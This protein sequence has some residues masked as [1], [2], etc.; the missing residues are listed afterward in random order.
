MLGIEPRLVLRPTRSSDVSWDVSLEMPDLSHLLLRFP[1]TQ[2]IL[3]GSR[4]VVAGAS[5][6]PLARGRLL[7]GPQRV[8]LARWPRPH[9]VLLRFEHRDSQLD[10][11]LRT[12]CLLRPG[13]RWLFRIAS[14]GL[15]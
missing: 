13:P 15:A 10:Y 12:E 2:G 5:G 4:C 3:T 7:H 11:L 1:H 14:D 8:M 6:R 9:E